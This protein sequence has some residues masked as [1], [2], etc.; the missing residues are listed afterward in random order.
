MFLKLL[1]SRNCLCRTSLYKIDLFQFTE[2]NKA[3]EMVKAILHWNK[4]TC[5]LLSATPGDVNKGKY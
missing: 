4:Y 5:I 1:R 3:I 2:P